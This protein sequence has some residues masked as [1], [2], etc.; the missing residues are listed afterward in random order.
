[1]RGFG[2][3]MILIPS[4]HSRRLGTPETTPAFL[5]T[6]YEEKKTACRLIVP[7]LMQARLITC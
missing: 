2:H 5:C 6:K 3:A 4:L 1:M 7:L